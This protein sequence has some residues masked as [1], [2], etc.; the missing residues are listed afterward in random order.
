MARKKLLTETEIRRFMK[1]AKMDAMTDSK[2][3]EYGGMAYGRDS[4]ELRDT[5]EDLGA[6]DQFAAEEGDELA[7][8]EAPVDVDIDAGMEEE[9]A[10][11]LSPEQAT[12]VE[13]VIA[14]AVDE[15][16]DGLSPLGVQISVEGGVEDLEAEVGLEEPLGGG[17]ELEMTA[18]V[19]EVPPGEEDLGEPGGEIPPLEEDADAIVNE[20]ARRVARRLSAQNR[21]TKMVDE[22]TE[23]I[24]NRLTQK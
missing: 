13:D 8:D 12:A 22:L 9:P 10:I 7:A 1:L 20:V 17:E 6:E 11:E 3:E 21:K 14:A 5:E 4:S 19:A 24:F 18:D 23:R 15:L 16:V 2:I